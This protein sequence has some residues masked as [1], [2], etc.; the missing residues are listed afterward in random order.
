MLRAVP[1]AVLLCAALVASANAR[2]IDHAEAPYRPYCKGPDPAFAHPAPC[3]RNHRLK[4]ARMEAQAQVPTPVSVA[5]VAPVAPPSTGGPYAI[6]EYIVQ[7]ESG[8]NYAA[9][10]PSGAYGAYQIM[11]GTAAAYGC[12]LSTAAG[13]DTCAGRIYADVGTSAWACG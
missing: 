1:A 6:P 3:P 9:Q 10:N 4:L 7:C 11:P 2:P 5:P 8:G 13:Q 12:D